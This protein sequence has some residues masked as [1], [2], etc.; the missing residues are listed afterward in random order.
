[1]SAGNDRA[2]LEQAARAALRAHG[3]AEPNPTVGCVIEDAEGRFVAIGR[4]ARCGGPHA[5]V[6]ALRAAGDRARGG[7]AWVTLEP[8]NHHGRTPPCVDALIEAGVRRVVVGAID[9]NPAAAGGIERLRRA[10]VLVDVVDD[11]PAVRR[12]HAP[13]ATRVGERRPWV[14]AKWAETRDGDLVAPAGR[15]PT[16]SGRRSHGMVH[17]ERGRVDAIL[18]GIGT[19]IADDPRLDARSRRPRRHPHR[20]VV[21]PDLEMPES[22]RLAAIERGRSIVVFDRDVADRMPDRVDRI[23]SRGFVPM[24]VDLGRGSGDDRS[25]SAIPRDGWLRLLQDLKRHHDVSTVMTEAGPGLLRALLPSGLVDAALVFTA[26]LGF[27]PRTGRTPTPR[28]LLVD[29]GLHLAWTGRREEDRVEWWSRA[30]LD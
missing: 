3:D 29:A 23:V 22:P 7:T 21:D 28:D 26:P 14:V 18:T 15:S 30:S 25:F 27:E 6:V 4:T 9:P 12:L 13:F 2:R 5:E 10:G 24:A 16:I 1:M 20:V 8:C 19:V 11:V 17:R